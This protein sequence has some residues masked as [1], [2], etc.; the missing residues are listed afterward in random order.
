MAGKQTR[1]LALIIR[2]W[3]GRSREARAEV[4]LAL[5]ALALDFELDVYFTGDAILQLAED[6]NAVEALLPG[7]YRAWAALPD[8]GEARLFAESSWLKRCEKNGIGLTLPV[9][10]L[11]FGRMKRQWRECDQVVVL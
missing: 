4:D 11:G 7:G 1:R 5:A 6:R 2:S 8:L 9:E 10:G 3:P